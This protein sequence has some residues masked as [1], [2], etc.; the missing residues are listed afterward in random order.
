M[1]EWI[2]GGLAALITLYAVVRIGLHFLL[3]KERYK[4]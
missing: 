3:R 4:G 2:I 1:V